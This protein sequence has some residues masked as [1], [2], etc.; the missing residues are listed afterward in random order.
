MARRPRKDWIERVIREARRAWALDNQWEID[1]KW[2]DSVEVDGSPT[3]AAVDVEW[4]A[5][6]LHIQIDKSYVDRERLRRDLFHEVGHAVVDEP[7][8][9]VVTDWADTLI[10]AGTKERTI[11]E[12]AWNT[13]CNQVIDHVA[14]QIILK[15]ERR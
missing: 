11:F 9:R 10:P 5:K 13:V 14:Y 3:P 2:V 1:V 8:W 6:K 4:T 12:E 15:R 7:L